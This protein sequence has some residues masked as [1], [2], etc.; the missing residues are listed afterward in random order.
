MLFVDAYHQD[1]TPQDHPPPPKHSI[2]MKIN[3]LDT[4]TWSGENYNLYPWLADC[5]TVFTSTRVKLDTRAHLSLQ[6]MPQKKRVPFARIVEWN[7]VS[8]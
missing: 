2:S 1:P 5:E 7:L 3:K 6:A 8:S 4:P